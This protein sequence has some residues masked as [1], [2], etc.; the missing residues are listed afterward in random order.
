MIY[1]QGHVPPKYNEEQSDLKKDGTQ[2]FAFRTVS[3]LINSTHAFHCFGVQSPRVAV[4]WQSCYSEVC[5]N[6]FAEVGKLENVSDTNSR[7]INN[8]LPV[9]A[10]ALDMGDITQSEDPL[11]FAI[12]LFRNVTISYRDSG[13]I[14]RQW[15]ERISPWQSRWSNI[16][17]AV[18]DF[19]LRW[20]Q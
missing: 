1:H 18:Y 20:C 2:F 16:W 4:T 17:D 5:R 14:G 6:N 3:V 12:G 15:V 7:A 10:F 8:N 11:V 13:L 9:M 19:L